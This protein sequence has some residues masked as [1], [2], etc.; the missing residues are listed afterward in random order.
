MRMI[1]ISG[2]RKKPLNA[3]SISSTL[4][5][6]TIENKAQKC[7]QINQTQG[8]TLLYNKI[9]RSISSFRVAAH[10]SKKKARH[11]VLS[12][13]KQK[14][15]QAIDRGG[16]GGARQSPK[17]RT[18]SPTIATN[19]PCFVRKSLFFAI[20]MERKRRESLTLQKFRLLRKLFSHSKKT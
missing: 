9:I 20:L 1:T 19:C 7:I 6:E 17:Q 11:C 12:G 14:K 4:V 15:R 18:S 13:A 2:R 16:G 8:R 3:S 5:S 10:A